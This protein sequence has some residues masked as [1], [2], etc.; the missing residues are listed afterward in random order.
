MF[1]VIR[2]IFSPAGDQLDSD[3]IAE[4]DTLAEAEAMAER[5]TAQDAACPPNADEARCEW[6]VIAD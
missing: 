6:Y 3:S 5:L 2:K 4:F 1:S